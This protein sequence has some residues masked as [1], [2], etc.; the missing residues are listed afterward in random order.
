MI[1]SLSLASISDLMLPV[2]LQMQFSPEER[3][4]VQ[5]ILELSLAVLL[6]SGELVLRTEL[7]RRRGAKTHLE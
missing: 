7:S 1:L 6:Q 2:L 4:F 3:L 5:D